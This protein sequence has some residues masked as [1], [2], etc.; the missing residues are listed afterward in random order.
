MPVGYTENRYWLKV[1]EN[2]KI[3]VQLLKLFGGHKLQV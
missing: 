2:Y 1:M 3:I